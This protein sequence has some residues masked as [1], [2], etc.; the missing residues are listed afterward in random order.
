MSSPSGHHA[1]DAA[2]LR[3]G[4]LLVEL[5]QL[6]HRQR[7]RERRIGLEL[8]D[9]HL[10][11]AERLSGREDVVRRR[12]EV[13]GEQTEPL[14]GVYRSRGIVHEIDGMGAVEEVTKRIFD[15][16]DVVPQS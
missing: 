6:R 14:I 2:Y 9:A 12:Q 10:L 13:Y 16:L 15:A 7:V 4:L 8:A 11:E 3:G 1:R 5:E